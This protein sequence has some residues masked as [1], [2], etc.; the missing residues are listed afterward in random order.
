MGFSHIQDM[1]VQHFAVLTTISYPVQLDSAA[2]PVAELLGSR[3]SNQISSK[4][5]EYNQHCA[6]ELNTLNSS[7]A[8]TR[9]A[10][11]K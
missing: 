8:T 7:R 11:Q 3:K 9:P 2:E 6:N 10:V 1:M 5:L 4:L